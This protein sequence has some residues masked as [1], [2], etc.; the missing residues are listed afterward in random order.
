MWIILSI[1]VCISAFL[2]IWSYKK[3]QRLFFIFKPLT[4]IL[5]IAIAAGSGLS[6]AYSVAIFI[7]LIL[8]LFGDVFL[9]FETKFIYGLISFLLAHI[10]Y[11]RAFY[12]GFSGLGVYVAL[13]LLAFAVIMMSQL[14]P[15]AGKLKIPVLIYISVILAMVY[16]A[17]E[18]YLQSRTTAALLVFVGALLF[19]FSDSVLAINRF[20]K[21]FSGAQVLILSSYYLAQWLIASS[22][23]YG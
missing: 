5:I 21:E 3:H 13:P 7:A 23:L 2:T 1:F 11:I 4:T 8:S 15:N 19:A 18:M 12:S 10:V 17:A 16:Q 22:C 14:W 6:S 9:L 20:K